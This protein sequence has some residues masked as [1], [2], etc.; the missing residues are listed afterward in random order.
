[1]RN[2]GPNFEELNR[3][4][5]YIAFGEGTGSTHNE[6]GT[7]VPSSSAMNSATLPGGAGSA[8]PGITLRKDWGDRS[9]P[10]LLARVGYSQASLILHSAFH[11]LFHP[12]C[13]LTRQD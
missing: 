1:M 4:I 9:F 13:H 11:P 7:P 3:P 12:R 6:A 2:P 8:A 10:E 5:V